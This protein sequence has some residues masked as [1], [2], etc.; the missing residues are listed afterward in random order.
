MRGPSTPAEVHGDDRK[1]LAPN[2]PR[3]QAVQPEESDRPVLDDLGLFDARDGHVDGAAQKD[4]QSHEHRTRGAQAE[5]G[6]GRQKDV[7]QKE[8]KEQEQAQ[9]QK[10]KTPSGSRAHGR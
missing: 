6:E 9:R 4:A 10:R 3:E 2:G 7:G 8:R 1:R 5:L